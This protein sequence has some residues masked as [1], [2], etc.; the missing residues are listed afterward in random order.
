MMY[1]NLYE[2]DVIV[3]VREDQIWVSKITEL[4]VIVILDTADEFKAMESIG[5][6][7]A[8]KD[9]AEAMYIASGLYDIRVREENNRVE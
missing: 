6:A 8:P 3:L 4:D 1:E 2:G 9:V 5:L 7:A